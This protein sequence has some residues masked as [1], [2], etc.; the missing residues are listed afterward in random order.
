M[1][2][3]EERL[4]TNEAYFRSVNERV[5]E[6]VKNVAGEDARFNILCECSSMAC[7]ERI[8]VTP[9]EYEQAHA[10]PRQFIV[11]HGHAHHEIEDSVI[12]TDRFEIVRK[13]GDAGD[14]A[15]QA[16]DA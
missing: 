9:A 3:R 11:A 16:A 10:D 5:E 15:A 6:Q 2:E 7:A 14:V 13:H 4:A 1:S 12:Q 8:A